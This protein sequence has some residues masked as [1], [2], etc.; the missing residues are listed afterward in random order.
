M[1]RSKRRTS[2]RTEVIDQ[3]KKEILRSYISQRLYSSVIKDPKSATQEQMGALGAMA[4]LL[5][6]FLYDKVKGRMHR[7]DKM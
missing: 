6:E 2:D 3:L 7:Y 5:A 1:A 4:T